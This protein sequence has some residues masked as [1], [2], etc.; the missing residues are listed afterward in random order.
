MSTAKSR[1]QC[2]ND[3]VAELFT[4]TFSYYK[5]ADFVSY[6]SIEA[7]N[8]AELRYPQELLNSIEVGSSLPDHETSLKKDFIVILLRNMKPSV[9][10]VNS[11]R[12]VAESMTHNLLFL[13]SVFGSKKVDRLMYPR[14]N[15]AVNKDDFPTP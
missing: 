7:Q 6:D 2:I 15:F 8:A 4:G 5:S 9:G 1:L 10:H 11:A 3:Q 13:R 14:M 12:Y